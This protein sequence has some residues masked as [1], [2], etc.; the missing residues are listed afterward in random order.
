MH[1]LFSR[2]K[3]KLKNTKNPRVTDRKLIMTRDKSFP[4]KFLKSVVIS[5]SDNELPVSISQFKK[6][7]LFVN[8]SSLSISC[9]LR[10][11]PFK[12]LAIHQE[13]CHVSMNAQVH[14]LCNKKKNALCK[15]LLTDF[16]FFFQYHSLCYLVRPALC[17]F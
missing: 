17:S 7:L 13:V 4:Y 11:Q 6:F 15:V 16:I 9:L 10:V 3:Q 12:L 5:L 1:L 14:L 8:N 2:H